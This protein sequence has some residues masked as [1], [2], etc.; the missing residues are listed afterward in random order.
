[1]TED[2]NR[3]PMYN[4]ARIWNDSSYFYQKGSLVSYNRREAHVLVVFIRHVENN[5][6]G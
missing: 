1:M 6:R 4:K 2:D 3:H 5:E